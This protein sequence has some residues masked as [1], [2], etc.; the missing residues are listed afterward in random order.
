MSD[1]FCPR[2]ITFTIP[3]SPGVVIVATENGGSIDFTIDAQGDNISSADIRGLFFDINESKLTG[4]TFSGGD[5]Y[6]SQAVVRANDVINLGHGVN[7]NGEVKD[8]FDV[9]LEW[10]TPGGGK[11]DIDFAV[12]FT[13]SNAAGNLTLDDIAHQRF[14]V[15]LDSIGGPGDPRAG[16]V[17]KLVTVAPAAPDAFDDSFAVFEDGAADLNSPSKTPAGV[18]LNVLAND[19][20]GDGDALVITAIHDGPAHGD[21]AIAAD[22]KSLIYTPDADYA[23]PDAF[24]YCVSDGD[25][26]QD[27]A[28][29]TID[30]AAVADDPVITWTLAQ[31]ADVNAVLITVTAS[32][33]DA[34]ASEYVDS[35]TASVAGGLP[36]GVTVTPGAVNPADDPGS[37]VQTFTVVTAPGVDFDFDLD[38]TAVTVERSNGD[39]ESATQTQ[40]IVIDYNSETQNG[41][42]LAADQSIWSEGDSFTFVDDRFIGVDTGTFDESLDGPFGTYAGVDGHIK[43][44]LQSTLTFEGGSIDATS[45]YDITAQTTYNRTLDLLHIGTAALLTNAFFSTQGPEGS[46][47]LDFV[48]DVALRAYAGINLDIGV[49]TIDEE[50]DIFDF[51]TGAGSVNLIDLDSQALGGTITLPAPLD[52]LSVDFAWPHLT[53]S[54]GFPP[55]VNGDDASNNFLQLNLDLDQAVTQILGVPNVFDPPK[56]WF[57]PFYADADLLDVDVSAGLNFL[58]SFLLSMGD[59]VGSLTFENGDTQTF[60]IGDDLLIADASA[61]DAGGDNDGVVEFAFNLVPEASLAN[62]T[63]L[64]FNVG[65]DIDLLELEVGYDFEIYSD[66]ASFGPLAEFGAVEPVA[67]VTVFSDTFALNFGGSAFAFAA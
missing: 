39:T 44:G 40:A 55:P 42:F 38:F 13:M 4:L 49:T 9:G 16:G 17:S 30:V 61:I 18:V 21:V 7:L 60:T 25:G 5:G 67:S 57:G 15:R 10:G 20:D 52:A 66:S 27:H 58:Q 35:L 8:K 48:Y 28:R 29:V 53:T 59:L 23:G 22:G 43:L 62:Q 19:T 3:G 56:I 24:E 50:G 31:G 33:N 47:S 37:I 32:Q 63:D 46:Y 64:G 36:A 41:E 2:Q 14:G 1:E 54:G 6:L 51:S 26:G 65:V 12:S 45:Q 34:D 11:D